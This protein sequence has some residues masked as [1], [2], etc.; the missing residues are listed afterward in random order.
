MSTTQGSG[1]Y[2]FDIHPSV[3]LQLGEEL[4]SDEIQALVELVKN[5]Y[6][7]DASYVK[8]VVDTKSKSDGLTEYKDALGYIII[9]DDGIGMDELTIKRAWLT[10]SNSPKRKMKQQGKT[11]TRGRTPLGD[12]GL[13]RLGA[14]RLADNV[15]IFTRTSDS[16][17]EYHIMFSW[18]D[19]LKDDITLTEVPVVDE[20]ILPNRIKGTK[21]IL[22]GLRN[23]DSWTGNTFE[24]LERKLSQL[25]SPYREIDNFTIVAIIDGKRID[26]IQYSS[27]IRKASIINYK[28]NFDGQSFTVHGKAKMSYFRIESETSKQEHN[29]FLVSDNGEK[30]FDYLVSQKKAKS[31][32]ISRSIDTDWYVEYSYDRHIS[33][34]DKINL[35]DARPANPGP[36]SGEVDTFKLNSDEMPDAYGG[37]SALKKFVQDLG[38]IRVFRDGFGIRVDDDWLSLSKQQTSESSF[39]GLRP[40]NTIGYI[41]LSAKNN[42][43]LKETTDREGFVKSNAY[44]EN[45]ILILREFVKFSHDAQAFLRRSWNDFKKQQKNNFTNVQDT[46]TF[47]QLT[48]KIKENISLTEIHV[49]SLEKT[50]EPIKE[51][52]EDVKQVVDLLEQ[53]LPTKSE[54]I[55]N[56]HTSTQNLS[57]KLDKA[58][59]DISRAETQSHTLSDLKQD[60]NILEA[61]ISTLRNQLDILREQLNQS[62]ETVSLGLTTE[63]LSHEMVRI[64]DE[65]AYRNRF[66]M[67]YLI[68]KNIKDLE[69]NRFTTHI[70]TTV[71]T[72]RKQLSH[73][74]PS[75]RYVRETKEQISLLEYFKEVA[76]FYK[77]R[78]ANGNIEI[79][80]H[81]DEGKGFSLLMNRGKLNQIIDNLLLNSEYWLRE[82]MRLK[83]STR[84]I[85]TIG[86]DKPYVRVHDNGRGIEPSVETS[87]FEPFV[88]TKGQGRGRGLGLFIVQQLLDTENCTASV[89]SKRNKYNHLYVFELDFRGVIN[90]K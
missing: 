59:T 24:E 69:L 49:E 64:V 22:S 31:F 56:L 83:L 16:D 57:R 32:R 73:L 34:I 2:H 6:D 53:P 62:Y 55:Q 81:C 48:T 15:D 61:Q 79:E 50:R 46:Q 58:W 14:Q 82:D 30:F 9:E 5:S 25:I 87:L 13:G 10:V 84:G 86:L 72:M 88:T 74:S 78:F 4:I 28:L 21:I 23:L 77:K 68:A 52:L 11:T 44:Y 47:E 7:A 29:D 36:F 75:L 20:K 38:G 60:Y 66:I 40:G 27:Q 89:L 41:A 70:N 71:S 37:T 51:V 85:I 90:A 67:D 33:H 18:K 26:L 80:I 65:L 45:F 19:F 1:D 42:A 43:Q 3:V 54:D 63:S 39:Y 17:L 8:V 76:E 35:I 12:K